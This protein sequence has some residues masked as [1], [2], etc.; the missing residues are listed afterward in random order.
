MHTQYVEVISQKIYQYKKSQNQFGTNY[1]K[2]TIVNLRRAKVLH[3]MV[4]YD[5]LF[6]LPR[7]YFLFFQMWSLVFFRLMH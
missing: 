4:Y 5:F 6:S 2:D 3:A 7:L 1:F